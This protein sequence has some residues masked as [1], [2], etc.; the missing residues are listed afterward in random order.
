[1]RYVTKTSDI[2][3]SSFE[4]SPDELMRCAV[5][6]TTAMNMLHP[7]AFLPV[8]TL[9]EYDDFFGNSVNIVFKHQEIEKR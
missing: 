2:M 6:V 4:L 7:T 3:L 5:G 9:N 8:A 1:M